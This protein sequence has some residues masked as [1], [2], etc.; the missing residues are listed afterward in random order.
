MEISAEKTK[1]MTN[2]TR[3]INKEIKVN[4]QKLKKVTNFKYSGSVVSDDGSK[5]E[6]LSRV[7]QTTAALTKLESVWND[8]NISLS[9]KIR[10]IRSIVTSIFLYASDS[11]TVTAELQIRIRATKMRCNRK[12]LR[13]S[14]KIYVTN[15]EVH[16]KIHQ[17][18]RTTRR[19]PDHGKKTQTAVIWT[20]LSFIRSD[21]NHL[22]RHIER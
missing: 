9:S 7:A 8:R 14:Y 17:A 16:G 12:M 18:N 19:P 11:W 10:M 2:K 21:Q 22:A 13:I 20:C 6:I 15:K 4:R 5:P 3:C 1:F